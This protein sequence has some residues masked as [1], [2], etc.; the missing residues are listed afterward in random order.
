MTRKLIFDRFIAVLMLAT[1]LLVGTAHGRDDRPQ[2]TFSAS[3][4]GDTILTEARVD[5]PVSP[6]LVWMVLTDYA[7]YPRFISTMRESTVLSRSP[8]G[9]LVEQKGSFD[10]LFFSQ[11]VAIHLLVSEFPPNVIVARAVEG[12]FRE[13]L[14]RY[15]LRAMG[16]GVRLLYSGRV[17][18]E[19]SLPPIIGMK[20]VQFALQDNFAQM[21]DEI[22]RRQAMAH[23]TPPPVQR[24]ANRP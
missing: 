6:A 9:L 22:M 3:L 17:I 21:V 24:R 13:M 4:E 7:H 20:L 12:D 16:S 11:D 15:E 23:Q 10:F 5:L 1:L 19:F 2:I 8:T 18:P 14:G